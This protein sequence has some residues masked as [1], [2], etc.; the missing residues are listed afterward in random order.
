M[1]NNTKKENT[2]QTRKTPI[3]RWENFEYKYED[4]EKLCREEDKIAEEL[5]RY[6]DAEMTKTQNKKGN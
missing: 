3:I 5:N 2:K 1:T 6:L 4:Y